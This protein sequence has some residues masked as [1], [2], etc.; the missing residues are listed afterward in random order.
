M[1]GELER[2]KH[3]AQQIQ[4][5]LSDFD[6]AVLLFVEAF[7]YL[8]IEESCP[9]GSKVFP[10]V[11][12]EKSRRSKY[13]GPRSCWFCDQTMVTKMVTLIGHNLTTTEP[14]ESS[15]RLLLP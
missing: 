3:W 10:D 6:E 9:F 1:S 7:N 15:L 8:S 14:C 4:V 11:V 12:F 5:K 13:P 2:A